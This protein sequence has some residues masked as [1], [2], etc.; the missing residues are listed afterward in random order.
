MKYRKFG[1][2]GVEVSILGFGALRFPKKTVNNERVTDWDESVRII[3]QSIDSGI[4]F[5]DSAYCY[6]ESEKILGRILKDGYREKVYIATKFPTWLAEGT[7]DFERYLDEELERL[8][9]DTI[10]FYLFHALHKQLWDNV[11]LR[12]GLIERALKA[13]E[14][15]KINHLGFSFHDKPE[16]LKEIIDSGNFETMLVQYN[17]LDRQHEAMID[18]AASRGMGVSVMGPLG[19]GL[20]AGIPRDLLA[21][22]NSAM[23]AQRDLAL[24]FVLSNPNVHCAFSGMENIDQIEE[25]VNIA[26]SKLELTVQEQEVINEIWANFHQKTDLYC[27]V[28]RYC[29]PCPNKIDIAWNFKLLNYFR[30]YDQLQNYAREEYKK[31]FANPNSRPAEECTECGECEA[32]CPQKIEII[33]QLQMVVNTLKPG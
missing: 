29:L 14:E 17:I 1:K 16:V 3:R 5:I 23:L 33:K 13:K 18:Y 26:S 21:D 7:D 32:R 24:R 4:N 8:E 25:N 10:D 9:I 11:V 15:G 30:M 12:Y 19:G 27:T 2:T 6:H 20:L 31:L 22:N 28:C